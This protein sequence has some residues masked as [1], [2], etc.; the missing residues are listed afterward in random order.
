MSTTT[1]TRQYGL[2]REQIFQIERCKVALINFMLRHPLGM[3]KY[4]AVCYYGKKFRKTC[5]HGDDQIDLTDGWQLSPQ[6]YRKRW[7]R[8][9]VLKTHKT[10][11]KFIHKCFGEEV[12]V[13]WFIERHSAQEDEWGNQIKKGSFHSNLFVGEIPDEAIQ[14]PSPHLLPLFYKE[15][16]TG[17]PINMRNNDLENL[18]VLLLNACIRQAKW[19]GHHPSSLQISAVPPEEMNQTIGYCL[20]EITDSPESFN[21]VIDREN[22]YF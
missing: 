6:E 3:P 12:P 11:S 9:E 4:Y 16:E 21:R 18:K 20:K 5:I 1:T 10:I 7:D 2:K 17:I 19:V 8:G 15:D 13:W 14:N 22:S